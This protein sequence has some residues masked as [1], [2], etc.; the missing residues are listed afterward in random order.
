MPGVRAGTAIAPVPHEV[1]HACRY[2][3]LAVMLAC[4]SLFLAPV[5]YMAQ[6]HPSDRVRLRLD[7]TEAVAAL[8][9][10]EARRAGGAPAEADRQRLLSSQGYQRLKTREAAMRRAFTDSSFSAFLHSDSLG[11]R[12][13]ELRHA[14]TAWEAADLR[15][16]AARALAYLPDD[17]RIAATVYVMIKPR[18]NSFVWDVETNPAIFLYLDPSRTQS[19]FANTVAH[20]LHHI[21][22]ASVR[23]RTDS[24]LAGLPDSVKTAAEWIGAFGEGFAML[25]AA[26]GPDVHPHA[27][28]PAADRAR[29]DNDMA[30]FNQDLR[31]LEE[32]FRDVISRRLATP[33][34]VRA[35]AASFYGIQGPWY[36]VGWRMAVLIEKAFGRDELIRCMTD[37]R[38]LLE[39]YNEAAAAQNR[40]QRD[41]LAQ[42]SPELIAALGRARKLRPSARPS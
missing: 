17:A 40:A 14:L 16:A 26:G 37:P 39:R 8:A 38:R 4:C 19:Q 9:I 13:G 24:L 22:F 33:D 10:L 1:L 15:A 36:T 29:W 21:G 32:F 34:T 3:F 42:W 31:T 27:E 41:S 5:L 28:S 30:R 2:R 18:T 35:V 25:A 7:T 20:E 11:R 12:S 23:A 6:A